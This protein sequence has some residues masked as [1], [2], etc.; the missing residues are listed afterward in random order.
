M[1][2]L[3]ADF[4]GLTRILAV[5]AMGATVLSAAQ[6]NFAF[7]GREGF[8]SN[9]GQTISGTL[10]LDLNDTG[11]ATPFS[12]GEN[13]STAT[14]LSAN[15]FLAGAFDLW[16]FSGTP[17]VFVQDGPSSWSGGG[18]NFSP[19]YWIVRTSVTGAAIGG[20]TPVFFGIY[21]YTGAGAMNGAALLPPAN[22][23][24]NINE[25]DFTFL[26]RFQDESE[27]LMD[28]TG[29]IFSVQSVPEPTAFALLLLGGMLLRAA[30]HRQS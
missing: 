20:L 24:T 1:I 18:E 27:N 15:H 14:F 25:S 12:N 17:G 9:T 16:S 23:L 13:G 5:L 26:L 6:A 28:I 29:P 3:Q 11:T 8:T 10:S 7:S 4:S 21:Y 19:D 2:Q 22:P 30:K